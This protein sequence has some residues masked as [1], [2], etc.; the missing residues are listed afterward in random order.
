[1]ARR[2]P[3]LKPS[4]EFVLRLTFPNRNIERSRRIVQHVFPRAKNWEGRAVFHLPNGD[5]VIANVTHITHYSSTNDSPLAFY[6]A[7]INTD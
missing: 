3:P 6:G 1:M 7:Q 2:P 5:T 4:Y